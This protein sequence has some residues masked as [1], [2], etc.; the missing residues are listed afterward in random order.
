MC[1]WKETT[2]KPF[3]LWKSSRDWRGSSILETPSENSGKWYILLTFLLFYFKRLKNSRIHCVSHF[4][5]KGNIRL[6]RYHKMF[7]IWNPLPLVRTCSIVVAPSPLLECSNL[8]P[9]TTTSHY[10]ETVTLHKISTPENQ[11]KIRYFSQ[12]I[13]KKMI[14][15][16]SL[17]KKSSPEYKW[18]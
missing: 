9:N 2:I 5:F 4:L 6:L 10:V 16:R 1:N 12:C 11:V 3:E 7:K 15:E 8:N 14:P 17:E 13:P 18:Y